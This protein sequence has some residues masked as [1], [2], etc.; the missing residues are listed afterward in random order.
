MMIL[1]QF[2]LNHFRAIA[3]A[4]AKL[5]DAAVS[6][7][8]FLVAVAQYFHSLL[9][10]QSLRQSCQQASACG[11]IA[12]L[13]YGDHAIKQRP[14]GFGFGFSGLDFL[15]DNNA[16]GQVAQHKLT[17][18]LSSVKYYIFVSM[19]HSSAL[20]TSE[21]LSPSLVV[22]ASFSILARHHLRLPTLLPPH[23]R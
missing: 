11:Q 1:N 17:W 14:D 18:C 4:S 6:A 15:V 19:P 8:T 12:G 21:R 20:I 16:R 2:D 13:R 22:R 23:L 3:L 9:D 10:C 7:W 5:Y